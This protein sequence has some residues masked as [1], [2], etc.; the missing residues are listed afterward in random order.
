MVCPENLN[1]EHVLRERIWNH[2]LGAFSIR[3]LSLV[4]A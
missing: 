2:K 4:F 3:L 1:I